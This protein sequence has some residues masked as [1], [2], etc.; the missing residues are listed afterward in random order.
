MAEYALI[1]YLVF[2]IFLMI[3]LKEYL[4]HIHQVVVYGIQIQNLKCAKL[5]F[6]YINNY[7]RLL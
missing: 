6:Q 5:N 3:I 4:H 1:K 7:F 2:P